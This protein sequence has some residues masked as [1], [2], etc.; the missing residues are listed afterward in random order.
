MKNIKARW[1]TEKHS[2][3]KIGIVMGEDQIDGT[4]RA[5]IGTGHVMADGNADQEKIIQ[6]GARFPLQLAKILFEKP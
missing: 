5:Y 4:P 6:D 2:N 1:F 3:K